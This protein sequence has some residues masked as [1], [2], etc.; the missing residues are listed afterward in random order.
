MSG[1]SAITNV[2]WVAPDGSAG[3]FVLTQGASP[4]IPAGSR[5]TFTLATQAGVAT[6]SVTFW[7]DN[8]G[9]KDTQ[10]QG[11]GKQSLTVVLP[12]AVALMTI[13]V[14]AVGESG[15][16]D[17]VTSATFSDYELGPPAAYRIKRVRNGGGPGTVASPYTA[18]AFETVVPVTDNGDVSIVISTLSLGQWVVVHQDGYTPLSGANVNIT[19]SG[20]VKL[21]QP[22]PN[23]ANMFVSLVQWTGSQSQESELTWFNAGS[24]GGYSVR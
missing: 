5:L 11:L 13:E 12:V 8:F 9:L 6:W 14:Q 4:S 22:A 23:N 17:V 18:N 21:A 2:S 1:V 19:A 10:V 24:T 15:G 7:S 16:R 3:S 20:G